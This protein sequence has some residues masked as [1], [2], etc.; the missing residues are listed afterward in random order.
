M[1]HGGEGSKM[2]KKC[3]RYWEGLF[4]NG[5]IKSQTPSPFIFCHIDCASN[6]SLKHDMNQH[7][8]QFHQ[9]FMCSLYARRSWKRKKDWQLDCLFTILGLACV[10]A[11][12]R[13]L[14]KLSLG[15]ENTKLKGFKYLYKILILISWILKLY[16]C[17]P[18][19]IFVK[20]L[21]D[22]VRL[23]FSRNTFITLD[24]V[25]LWQFAQFYYDLWHWHWS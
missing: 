24:F 17:L 18:N 12:R 20:Y 14:T 11:V 15:F 13:M 6:V 23:I 2:W 5:V 3:H 21:F 7:R 10:K 22:M 8:C 16:I 1:T 4:I 25:A 19:V 9:H